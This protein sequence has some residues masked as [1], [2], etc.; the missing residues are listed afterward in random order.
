[1]IADIMYYLFNRL[2][3]ESEKSDAVEGWHLPSYFRRQRGVDPLNLMLLLRQES[4]AWAAF[5]PWYSLETSIATKLTSEGV[6]ME[7]RSRSGD[8]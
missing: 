5:L 6:R 1:M 4:N 7:K 8:D 2:E 3:E